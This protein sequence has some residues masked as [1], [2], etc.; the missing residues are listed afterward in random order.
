MSEPRQRPIPVT[1]SERE[2]LDTYKKSYQDKTGEQ[3]DWGKFLATLVLLGLAA[4]GVYSFVKATKR[5]PQSVDIECCQCQQ[6]FLMAVP[7]GTSRAIQMACPHCN[8]EL[9]VDLGSTG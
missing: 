6:R 9:V 2:V 1:R 3:P 8:A 7:S 5:S 4:A